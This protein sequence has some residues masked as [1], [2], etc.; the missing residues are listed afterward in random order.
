VNVTI[1]RVEANIDG[2]WVDVAQPAGPVTVNLLDLAR[3]EVLIGADQIP[4]G[5]YTQVRFFPQSVSVTDST[6]TQPVTVPSADQTGIKVNLNYT[7]EPGAVT[8]VLLDFNVAKSLKKTGNGRWQLQPVIPAVVKTA[9][10]TVAGRVVDGAAGGAPVAGAS[11]SAVYTAGTAYP[12]G[13]EVNTATSL[14]PDGVFKVWALLPGTYTV[15]AKLAGGTPEAPTERVVSVENVVVTA[16]QS[17][18]A[19]TLTLP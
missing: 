6:G 15:T 19:G 13:T 9:S 18:D 3:Q 12:V 5:A 16:G 11:V 4:A 14:A 7:V 8:S 2:E 10:G 17:A 1:G